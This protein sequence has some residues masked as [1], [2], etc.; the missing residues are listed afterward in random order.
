MSRRS[1]ISALLAAF[2]RT[3][4]VLA[5]VAALALTAACGDRA[6]QDDPSQAGVSLELHP[7]QL[8]LTPDVTRDTVEIEN[9]GTRA[10]TLRDFSIQGA[11]WASFGLEDALDHHTL[12]PGQRLTL[13]LRVD[14]KSLAGPGATI[15]S[16]VAEDPEARLAD[17]EYR[18]GKAWLRFSAGD[19][20][21]QL[22]LRFEAPSW[23]W[24]H[25]VPALVK[26]HLL[27]LGFVL[28]L[29]A[30]LTW[31]ERKQSALMQDRVGPNMARIQLGGVTLRLWGLLHILTDGIKMLFKEDFIPRHAHRALYTLAPLMA[32]APA[33]IVFAIVPFGDALCYGQLTEVVSQADVDRCAQGRGG[34]PL[35]IAQIDVG[36]LFYF[37]IASLA[38]Y[39]TTLAGWS[40]YNKWAVLGAL[41][42]SAQMISYEVALGLT[43]VGTLL[44]YGSLEPH[45]IVHAQLAS[46]WGI[47]LQPLAF[48]LFFTA[49]IAET[50]RAP[51]DL[52]EGESEI[53]GY[54][55]E[56]SGMR[57]GLFFLSEF[58]EVVFVS[59]IVT[60]L[61]LGGW[62]LPFGILEADGFASPLAAQMFFLGAGLVL[63]FVG[64]RLFR[65]NPAVR[66]FGACL[67]ALGLL[68]LGLAGFSLATGW[69]TALP[70]VVVLVIGLVTWGLKVVAL[71]WLQLL[72]RWTLPR[73][74]Y[75]QLMSL[76]WKGLLPLSVANIV[77]TA[78]VVYLL[79]PVSPPE[80]PTDQDAQGQPQEE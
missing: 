4:G 64:A 41:R 16:I 75:D 34:T 5:F 73:F 70:H 50:K 52:P 11:D 31:L 60:T 7:T 72:V 47:V 36:L 78:I 42:A 61:F 29:A 17:G 15:R 13:H 79:S 74:R 27:A 63:A 77:L 58:M 1:R 28:P 59:A 55:I 21:Q 45:A 65:S 12:L 9:T 19:E 46:T 66:N 62:A 35:Q 38:T 39:G 40:S 53:I 68:H 18:E 30:L 3:A 14:P 67:V 10:V 2:L 76:G 33:I 54:F 22:R 26:L 49:A 23:V 6:R 71:C 43:V 24:V 80:P 57:F 44:V 69:G 51:F 32:L 25:F 37:A 48:V 56:Y 20:P 8:V